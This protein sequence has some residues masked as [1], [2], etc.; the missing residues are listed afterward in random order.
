MNFPAS[1]RRHARAKPVRLGAGLLPLI[2][3]LW[4]NNPPSITACR[5]RELSPS[6]PP[7][8]TPPPPPPPANTHRPLARLIRIIKCTCPH[9][10][11]SRIKG[12]AHRRENGT[13]P[14][15]GR[16]FAQLSDKR[17]SG[18]GKGHEK[19]TCSLVP[20]TP[21]TVDLFPSDIPSATS[22]V[23]QKSSL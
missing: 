21:R 1:L 11:G 22:T 17:Q 9:A 16:K 5:P 4:Q 7:P 6:P 20:H 12:P 10:G 19:S 2:C 13:R 8:P 23:P 18:L 15:A 14:I 3:A